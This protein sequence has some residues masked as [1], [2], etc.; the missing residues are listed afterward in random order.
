MRHSYNHRNDVQ[1]ALRL[2]NPALGAGEALSLAATR[3]NAICAICSKPHHG[4]L[5]NTAQGPCTQ[6]GSCAASF[7]LDGSTG[8]ASYGSCFDDD[9]LRPSDAF[10]TE[11]AGLDP[12]CDACLA[13]MM[14]D[15]RI[16]NIASPVELGGPMSV[17]PSDS[18]AQAAARSRVFECF[19][20]IAKRRGRPAPW[21]DNH[22]PEP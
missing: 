22:A 8:R 19:A 1:L 12:V 7:S 13:L 9:V 18:E 21:I 16:A 4:Y 5:S 17:P 3:L 15:G 10:R 14:L 2:D 6:G 11:L 20:H